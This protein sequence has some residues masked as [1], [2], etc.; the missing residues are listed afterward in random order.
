MRQT[1]N[2]TLAA[3]LMVLATSAMA[4]ATFYEGQG[5]RG[6]AFTADRALNDFGRA[7]FNDRASSVAV[8]RGRWEVCEHADF[9]G[10]CAVLRP[11]NYASL[12]EM[13]LNDQISS[14]RPVRKG[15]RYGAIAPVP[16]PA[17]VY[18]YRRRPNERIH[19]VP[20]TSARAV[21]GPPN[22]RCW[23]E[24]QQVT[25]PSRSGPNVGGLILG[26]VLGGVLGHQVGGGTGKD[27]ATAGGAVAGAAIGANVG[28]NRN[29]ETY[30]RDVQRCENVASTT[31]EYWDVTYNYRGIEHRVQMASAPGNVIIVNDNGIPRE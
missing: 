29:T 14:V 24:R 27:I 31:P 9:G 17:P 26:G 20:V 16:A 22:Q 10:R 25:E 13:G 8:Q 4:Q 1:I 3:A 7:G 18:E 5:F 19:E 23:M 11:G 30:P 15:R 2:T 12:R 21:V 6:R 28:R